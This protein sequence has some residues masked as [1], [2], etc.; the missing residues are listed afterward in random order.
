MRDQLRSSGGELV[1]GRG[2]HRLADLLRWV[3]QRGD[4]DG[5]VAQVLTGKL[6]TATNSLPLEPVRVA[7]N[8]PSRPS[9]VRPE[10]V[11]A[12]QRAAQYLDLESRLL[13]P[14]PPLEAF[15]KLLS[16]IGRV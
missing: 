12:P 13:D 14:S 7:P 9:T 15:E 8:L 16:R 2:A 4:T 5:A 11:L 3:E 6:P 1:G 10:A